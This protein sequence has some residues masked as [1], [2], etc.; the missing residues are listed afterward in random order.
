MPEI[1]RFFGIVVAMYY[2]DH[3]PPHCHVRYGHHRAILEIDA[4]AVLAGSLPP[5]TLGLVIEWAALHRAELEGN[6][7][8]ARAQSPLKPIAPLE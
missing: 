1:S 7:L 8:R 2:D 3:P 4:V 5:R 6:W